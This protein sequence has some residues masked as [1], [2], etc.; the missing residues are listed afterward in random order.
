MM[1]AQDFFDEGY[2][3]EEPSTSLNTKNELLSGI[4]IGSEQ[5][6]EGEQV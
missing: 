4:S 5:E 1:N 3:D 6:C 2:N